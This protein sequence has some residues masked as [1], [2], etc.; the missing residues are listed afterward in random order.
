MRRRTHNFQ[1]R[2][3]IKQNKKYKTIF[4]AQKSRQKFKQPV[5]K[6]PN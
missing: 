1:K 2:N 3:K 5:K 6:T 4:K